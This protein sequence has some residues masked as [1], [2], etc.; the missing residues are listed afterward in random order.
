MIL[1]VL[2]NFNWEVFFFI[3]KSTGCLY[4]THG[5]TAQLAKDAGHD[6]V[7]DGLMEMNEDTGTDTLQ[8]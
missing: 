8:A 5:K 4:E 6:V 7:V 1:Q 3:P 2:A